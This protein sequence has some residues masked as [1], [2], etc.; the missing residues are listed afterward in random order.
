[1]QP[2][3][4]A[5]L[6]PTDMMLLALEVDRR[7]L[8]RRLCNYIQDGKHRDHRTKDKAGFGGRILQKLRYSEGFI[9]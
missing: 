1:M 5:F 3:F 9:V 6:G 8:Y 7:P 2:F 4:T